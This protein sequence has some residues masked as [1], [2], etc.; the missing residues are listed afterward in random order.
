[1]DPN[2]LLETTIKQRLNLNTNQRIL[3]SEF[4]IE[5]HSLPYIKKNIRENF[6]KWSQEKRN[7]FAILLGGHCNFGQTQKYIENLIKK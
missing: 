3:S 2:K 6:E 5:Y 4:K 7:K 1:M